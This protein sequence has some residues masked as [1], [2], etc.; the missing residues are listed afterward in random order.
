ME[1]ERTVATKQQSRFT[2]TKEQLARQTQTQLP[3]TSSQIRAITKLCMALRITTPLEERKMT[4][5]EAGVL[6]RELSNE[7]KA[8][9]RK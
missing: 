8:R 7:L 6:I 1:A 3:A 4:M 9:R 2:L 5:A